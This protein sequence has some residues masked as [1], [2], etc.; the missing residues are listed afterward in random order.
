MV[1]LRMMSL[2]RKFTYDRDANTVTTVMQELD[3]EELLSDPG[4]D[5]VHL[6]IEFETDGKRGTLR[7]EGYSAGVDVSFNDRLFGWFDFA[8]PQPSEPSQ[9]RAV[10][11]L[12]IDHPK[13]DDAFATVSLGGPELI[14]K[15]FSA[16]LP[17]GPDPIE[18]RPS[19]E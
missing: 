12:V 18:I 11:Q 15:V 4:P 1:V 3:T 13:Y 8:C 17:I 14:L 10:T 7:L 16:D 19:K 6:D 9:A 2:G 5:K